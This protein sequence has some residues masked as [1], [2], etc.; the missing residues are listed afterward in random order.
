[1]FLGEMFRDIEE[2][3]EDNETD[4]DGADDEGVVTFSIG[5]QVK[6]IAGKTKGVAT[7]EWDC[8]PV[9]DVIADSL[10]ALIM[11]AQSSAASIRLT[12][13][14]C[15]H[16]SKK[17]REGDLENQTTAEE[18]LRAVHQALSDQFLSVEATYEAKKG[19][20]E[21]KLDAN[22]NASEESNGLVCTATV[23]FEN[24]LDGTAKVT[25]EC[26]DEKLAANV[27]GCVQN[28]VAASAPIA[29]D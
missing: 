5:S 7:V 21:V 26:E 9:G 17:A 19:T 2:T 3:R 20:F 11:H 10:V 25:V 13:R 18:H 1:M 14:P 23:E 4:V 29:M 28:V 22:D 8:S 12:G 27:R 16:R 24:I 6:V 15:R